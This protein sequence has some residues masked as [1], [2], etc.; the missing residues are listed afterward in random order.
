[1]EIQMPT[2][3]VD[4]FGL[5]AGNTHAETNT[6]W[7]STTYPAGIDKL[8]AEDFRPVLDTLTQKANELKTTQDL[9]PRG[10][11]NAIEA[12]AMEAAKKIHSAADTFI[13]KLNRDLEEAEKAAPGTQLPTTEEHLRMKHR[14]GDPAERQ[15]LYSLEEMR[16]AE[17]RH[18]LRE[19]E[20]SQP[21]K[22]AKIVEQWRVK[23][24]PEAMGKLKTVRDAI[25][26][27]T[28]NR[29]NAL[30]AV[31]NLT[32]VPVIKDPAGFYEATNSGTKAP[33][34]E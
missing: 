20:K 34:P 30:Q 23:K 19:V 17:V 22:M 29:G 28:G 27:V 31:V 14:N 18:H 13:K 15:A 33:K 16:Q 25:G 7:N 9:S 3:N 21:G 2:L 24:D 12:A 6:H 4:Q 11:K 26:M 5:L 10:K 8:N 1:M 32:G